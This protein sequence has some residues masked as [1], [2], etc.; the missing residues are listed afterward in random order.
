M[1]ARKIDALRRSSRET[2][3]ERYSMKGVMFQ[4]FDGKFLLVC[5]LLV[6]TGNGFC[7]T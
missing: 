4:T 1:E 7:G 3:F 6:L 2:M 5:C